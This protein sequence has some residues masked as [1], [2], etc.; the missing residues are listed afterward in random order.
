[1]IPKFN[2]IADMMTFYFGQQSKMIRKAVEVSETAGS[3]THW[4][5]LYG[6]KVWSWL[7]LEANV[8]AMTPK[9]PWVKSGWRVLTTRAH[10]TSS[11]GIDES[12]TGGAI[13]TPLTLTFKQVSAKPK[14][15]AHTFDLGELAEFLG[16]VDDAVDLLPTYREEIGKEHAQAMCYMLAADAD[17]VAGVNLESLDRVIAAKAEID[18]GRYGSNDLDIYGLDRDS[19]TTNDAYVNENDNV[20]RDLSLTLIDTTLQNVWDNGGLPKFIL[21][22]TNTMMRW[23]QLIEAERR[24]MDTAK[25][26][27]T[28][29]GVR[30]PAPGIEAGF[31]VATYFG[32]PILP[33]IAVQNMST[34]GGIYFVDSD[35]VKL[36]VAKPTTYVESGKG[37][38]YLYRGYFAT[39]GM[40]ETMGELRAYRFNCHGKLVDLK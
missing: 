24:F 15:I 7:N 32:I 14:T 22:K 2:T 17:T 39:E 19:V 6:A 40:Y 11:G 4:E 31:M 36:A 28:F 35:Y 1:M 29:G 18:G 37:E 34:I 23:Q 5:P 10:S 38:G 8:F 33:S 30:G 27:P 12:T 25:V 21:T 3:G 26:V 9:E 16:T 20:D 13:P